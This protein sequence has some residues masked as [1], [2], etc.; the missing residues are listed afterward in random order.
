MSFHYH[1]WLTINL[2]LH[3]A[4][5][6]LIYVGYHA[7]FWRASF[8][9]NLT[10]NGK[11]LKSYPYLNAQHTMIFSRYVNYMEYHGK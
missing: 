6:Y 10:N 7:Q 1:S 3:M 2:H 11:V 9:M 8:I 5:C 4:N